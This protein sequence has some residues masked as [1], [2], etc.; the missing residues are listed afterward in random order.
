[1]CT[2][3]GQPVYIGTP[4]GGDNFKPHIRMVIDLSATEP[5]DDP[6]VVHGW[7]MTYLCNNVL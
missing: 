6:P 1:M 7:E 5:F 2:F 4:L 3:T